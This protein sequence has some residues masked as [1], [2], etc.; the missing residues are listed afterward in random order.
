MNETIKD[1]K[2]IKNKVCSITKLIT[3]YKQ[4]QLFKYIDTLAEED[5]ERLSNQIMDIDFNLMENL[6][7]TVSHANE[8]NTYTKNDIEPIEH[9]VLDLFDKTDVEEFRRIGLEAL[10]MGKIAVVTMAGGQGT[11]LGHNG[12]KGTIDIGLPTGKTLFQL[13]AERLRAVSERCGRKTPWYIMTS[14]E[15]HDETVKY[16][17]DNSYFD[18]LEKDIFFFKQGKLPMLN[19]EGKILLKDKDEVYFGPDG[20]GGVFLSLK[21]SGVLDDMWSKNIEWIF[22]CGIDNA[23]VRMADPVFIGYVI[24]TGKCAGSKSVL[25]KNPEEK[26]GVFCLEKG[27]PSIIEYTELPSEYSRMVRKNGELVFGESNIITHLFK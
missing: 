20:N 4:E 10:Q 17:I 6:Y 25:K 1:K 14:E 24:R 27:R 23:L 26:V 9:D 8:V 7:Q 13:Q 3:E 15:N 11:R 18:Y 22:F 21:K 16:F 5:L 12:P 2:I 19:I